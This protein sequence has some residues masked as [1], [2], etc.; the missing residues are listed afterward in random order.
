VQLIFI[1]NAI[2]HAANGRRQNSNILISHNLMYGAGGVGLQDEGGV[3]VRLVGNTIWSN[4][5]GSV[6]LRGHGAGRTSGTVLVG[7]LISKLAF[8]QG[9]RPVTNSFNV[10]KSHHGDND[11][12]NG[13]EL[14]VQPAFAAPATGNFT[15]M[16]WHASASLA[17]AERAAGATTDL[18][19]QPLPASAAPGAI[20]QGDPS[21]GF[22]AVIRA[23]H[24][25][26]HLLP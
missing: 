4:R 2:I 18:Y 14:G 25:R 5:L 6:W 17:A 23:R 10:I 9:N 19:G 3:D 13:N 20:Q 12:A 11:R 8:L 24:R 22:G 26:H 15:P 16:H 21:Q 7:N 1:Q